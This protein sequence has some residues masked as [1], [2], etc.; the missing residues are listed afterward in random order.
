LIKKRAILV[1]N[2]NIAYAPTA[3]DKSV[4]PFWAY[5]GIYWGYNM[6]I[7]LIYAA[8]AARVSVGVLDKA[9][10]GPIIP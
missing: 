9:E 2:R 6:L 4:A 5:R 10:N 3:T 7:L 1:K 8:F